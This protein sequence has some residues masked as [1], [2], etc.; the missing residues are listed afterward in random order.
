M[1]AVL[2]PPITIVPIAMPFWVNTVVRFSKIC[3]PCKVAL[4]TPGIS[5][6]YEFH[7][8]LTKIIIDVLK[9]QDF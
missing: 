6:W 8:F 1:A 3:L 5:Y 9:F 2:G 7:G 4:E